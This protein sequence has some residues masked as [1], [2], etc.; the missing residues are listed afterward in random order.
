MHKTH[1]PEIIF[2]MAQMTKQSTWLWL[3]TRE[4]ANTKCNQNMR[5]MTTQR[6]KQP[7]D[8]YYIVDSKAKRN[9]S[10]AGRTAAHF[11]LDSFHVICLLVPLLKRCL[12]RLWHVP[13]VSLTFS[14]SDCKFLSRSKPM[15]NYFVKT[16]WHFFL[17]VFLNFSFFVLFF[18]LWS[19]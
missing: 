15:I 18:F 17:V 10:S 16:K 8:D 4:T 2:R 7:L 19:L 12:S 13:F 3:C 11:Q 14:C 5:N 9:V 6:N 1:T